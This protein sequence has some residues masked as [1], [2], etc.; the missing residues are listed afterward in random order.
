MTCSERDG[1]LA[2]Y[3]GKDLEEEPRARLEEHL[4]ECAD[5][6]EFLS[7]IEEDRRLVA[8]FEPDIP[9][10]DIFLQG[11]RA[12]RAGLSM[13]RRI[14][15]SLAGAAAAIVI[16]VVFAGLVVFDLVDI[17]RNGEAVAVRPVE[18]ESV[19]YSQARVSIIP[20]SSESMTVI[21]IISDEVASRS[22]GG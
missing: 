21:W 8:G 13:R 1:D 2:L 6:R 10:A 5:C 11:V 14:R 3:A 16:A 17:G 9:P 15:Y 12:K 22:N 19:G 4:A 7:I 18:V 20:T